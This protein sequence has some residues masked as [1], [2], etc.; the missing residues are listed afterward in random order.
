VSGDQGCDVRNWLL[1]GMNVTD[2]GIAA[3]IFSEMSGMTAVGTD[4]GR[5]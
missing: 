1:T 2:Y 3:G 5:W 4:T